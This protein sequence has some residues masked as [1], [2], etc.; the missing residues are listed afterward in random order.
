[1]ALRITEECINCDVCEPQCP[2]NAIYMGTEIYEIEPSR[3]T[4]CVG[5]FDEPQCQV[6]CP[7]ECIIFDL[8]HPEDQGQLMAKYQKLTAAD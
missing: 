1:M 3:C 4:E 5:H 6:V 2:N 8:D 7:V